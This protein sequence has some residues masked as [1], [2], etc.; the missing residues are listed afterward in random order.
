MEL[1]V[2]SLVFLWT[3]PHGYIIL[4]YLHVHVYFVILQ[5]EHHFA[6]L[7]SS[8][9]HV[10]NSCIQYVS[11]DMVWR[12]T[13]QIGHLY[14]WGLFII[15]YDNMHDAYCT[16]WFNMEENDMN[17]SL[18]SFGCCKYHTI[19]D[20]HCIT[21]DTIWYIMKGYSLWIL[22][23]SAYLKSYKVWKI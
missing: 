9:Y 13:I 23:C 21:Y 17:E 10:V 20:M 1:H 18:I 8:E 5:Q 16:I 12:K 6:F 19:F 11:Y 7:N 4:T 3:F 22:A 15:W 14:H 2:T